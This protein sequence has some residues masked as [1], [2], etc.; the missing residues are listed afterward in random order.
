MANALQNLS[1]A[2]A[3]TIEAS[4]QSI[5]RVEGRRRQFASG[6]V[7]S[8]DGV[9]VTAHHVVERDEG[10][11]VG[12]PNGETV[13]AT[14]AGRD[15]TTDLVVLKTDAKGLTPA[16]W[17]SIDGQKVGHMVLAAGRPGRTV[18]AT[19]GVISA[20]GEMWRT[21]GGGEIDHYLQTD[22]VMYPGFSG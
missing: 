8:K 3:E 10:I 14:V 9:I 20:L 13:E 6:V 18:Q 15:A 1:Q 17:A 11:K 4:G 2:L 21:P 5:V 22:V 7:W 19:L 16:K 12:L